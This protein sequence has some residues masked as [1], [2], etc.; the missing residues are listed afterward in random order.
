[1]D[2]TAKLHLSLNVT[3]LDEAVRFYG[4]LFGA[5]PAKRRDD[6]AK[7]DVDEPGVVLALNLTDQE[8]LSHMGIRVETSAEVAQ[9]RARLVE[10]GLAVADEENVTCCYAVQDKAWVHDPSGLPWELYTVKA[11]AP[12]RDG[13]ATACCPTTDASETGAGACCS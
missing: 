13:A 6:Y 9:G 11:E 10:A 2:K 5:E 12:T 1:M 4:A 3:D 7:F 8:G